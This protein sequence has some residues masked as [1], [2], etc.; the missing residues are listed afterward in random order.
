MVY[1]SQ[2][3]LIDG[4]C[5]SNVLVFRPTLLSIVIINDVVHDVVLYIYVSSVSMLVLRSR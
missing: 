1:F 2:D 3:I 4:S 5:A